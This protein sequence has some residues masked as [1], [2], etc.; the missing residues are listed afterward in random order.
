M[1]EVLAGAALALVIVLAV[2]LLRTPSPAPRPTPTVI[3]P[4]SGGAFRE[5]ALHF[6]PRTE[7]LIG[8]TY[9]DFLRAIDPSVE[10]WIASETEAGFARFMVLAA[11][12]GVP[13]P[14]RFHAALVGKRITTWSRDRYTLLRRGDERLLLVP[15]R[16]NRGNEARENDWNAPFAIATAHGGVTVEVSPLVFDGGDMV[17]TDDNV[18]ATAV[19]PGRNQG[20]TYGDRLALLD[21]LRDTTG[22]EPVL[23]GDDPTRV[24]QHHI[25]MI[26]TPLGGKVVLVGDPDAGLRLLPADADLPRAVDRSEP[27]L[28]TFRLVAR[29]LEKQ[30]FDV[31]RVPLVPLDDGL[32][33]VSYNNA[34][35]ERR[36]D[37]KLHAYVPTFGIPPLDKAG[38]AVYEAAGVMVHPIDAR[39]IYAYNGTVRCLVNVLDRR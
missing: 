4:D 26:A 8:P 32:T 3:V 14:E 23:I 7:A 38:L 18:F 9:R 28:E 6:D 22:K 20:G 39:G 34:M 37:G 15:P 11:E 27:T 25:C 36:A 12:W 21:Y 33:Y 16:P 13:R 5:L 31:R 17:A 10:V 30:G 24:P 19:L 2:S 35:L 29:E 1:R